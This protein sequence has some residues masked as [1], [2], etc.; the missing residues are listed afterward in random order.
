[1]RSGLA[2]GDARDGAKRAGECGDGQ[3]VT[4]VPAA[5]AQDARAV[6]AD[7][8]CERGFGA[9]HGGMT[10][11]LHT[12]FHR[13][14]RLA[15]RSYEVFWDPHPKAHLQCPL[16]LQTGRYMSETKFFVALALHAVERAIGSAEK[17]FNGRAIVG[18]DGDADAD[19][20]R[21]LLAVAL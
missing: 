14:A 16:F 19:A 10:G 12:Y 1:M 17:L 7:V 21:G 20:D 11:D 15:T 2:V 9:G 4:R 13:D 5:I 18:I 3:S 6:R 8:F